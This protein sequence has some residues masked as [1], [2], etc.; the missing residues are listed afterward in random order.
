MGSNLNRPGQMGSNLNR[1]NTKRT[2]FKDLDYE[3]YGLE[4]ELE[5]GLYERKRRA[6]YSTNFR[7]SPVNN[8]RPNSVST[9]DIDITL[10]PISICS[11]KFF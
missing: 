7:Q 10:E 9:E 11:S 3:N 1:Q 2:S 4:D 8:H 6:A 5:M